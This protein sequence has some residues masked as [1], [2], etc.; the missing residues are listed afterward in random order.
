M[1]RLMIIDDEPYIVDWVFELFLQNPE[2]EL[3][4]YKA[5][6]AREAL[7]LLRRARIDIVMTDIR[8]PGMDGIQLMKEIRASWP[9]CRVIFLTSFEE[10][11]YLHAANRDGVTYLMKTQSDEEIVDAVRKVLADLASEAHREEIA[12]A[13][14]RQMERIQPVLQREYFMN[15]FRAGEAFQITQADLDSLGIALDA[16]SPVLLLLGRFDD[17]YAPASVQERALRTATIQ[18]LADA[19]LSARVRHA[20]LPLENEM[21]AWLIQPL[22]EDTEENAAH[23]FVK[24]SLDAI[25]EQCR[26]SL[27]RTFSFAIAD[28]PCAWSELTQNLSAL[29]MLL[30]YG[31]VHQRGIVLTKAYAATYDPDRS[32][33]YAYCVQ[34]FGL[35]LEKLYTLETYLESGRYQDFTGLLGQMRAALVPIVRKRPNLD[36]EASNAMALMLMQFVNRSERLLERLST[37]P[38]MMRLLSGTRGTGFDAEFETYTRI[39]EAIF[40][41]QRKEEER[42]ER[43]LLLSL[44]EHIQSNLGGDLSLVRLSEFANLNPAYLSRLYKQLSGVNLSDF[45]HNV[46]LNQSERLLKETRLKVHEIAT[47]IGFGSV[48]YFIRSFKKSTGMT[49][50][51]YRERQAHPENS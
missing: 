28:A 39:A 43:S 7:D 4:L 32:E 33:Q 42:K 40:S 1:H 26:A 29:S 22:S 9:A 44:N 23:L 34:Q 25:Q 30:S 45:I 49:P 15:A 21:L 18:T 31:G 2:L 8:M 38:D 19:T 17:W 24:E 37:L 16:S 14:R 6:S 46:R 50:Q 12:Q 10:V 47:A 41:G 48:A 5:Y 11:E 27:G 36:V 13:S 51:E 3:D 35:W 20:F